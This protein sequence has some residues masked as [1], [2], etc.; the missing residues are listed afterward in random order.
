ML[1]EWFSGVLSACA[2]VNHQA[3]PLYLHCHIGEFVLDGLILDNRFAE[4][5]ACR[6]VFEGALK[7]PLRE[8]HRHGADRNAA[9]IESDEHLLEPLPRFAELIL[10]GDFEIIKVKKRRV[11]AAQAELVFFFTHRVPVPTLFENERGYALVAWV[12]RCARRGV[13]NK[14]MARRCYPALASVHDPVVALG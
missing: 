9:T 2:V 7:C 4:L 3:R 6:G 12:F 8:T 1:S 5:N 10:V 13:D 14:G 11:G